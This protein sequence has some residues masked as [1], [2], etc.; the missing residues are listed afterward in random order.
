MQFPNV[1]MLNTVTKRIATSSVP[2]IMNASATGLSNSYMYDNRLGGAYVSDIERQTRFD[3]QINNL[4]YGNSIDP[5]LMKLF[6][7]DDTY[8]RQGKNINGLV[9]EPVSTR[10]QS[11]TNLSNQLQQ[12]GTIGSVVGDTAGISGVTSTTPSPSGFNGNINAPVN[13]TSTGTLISAAV[14]NNPKNNLIAN[15]AITSDDFGAMYADQKEGFLTAAMGSTMGSI[16]I[17]MIVMFALYLM[18]QTY[19]SQKKVEMMLSINSADEW[20]RKFATGF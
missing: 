3:D 2:S 9:S 12:T 18:I 6:N 5:R 16:V 20:R 10:A 1:G 15:G 7:G 4:L 11:M 8:D 17:C 19:L 13:G 14:A